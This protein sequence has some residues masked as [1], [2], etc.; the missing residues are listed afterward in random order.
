MFYLIGI[1]NKK[2]DIS[3]EGIDCIKEADEIYLEYYTSFYE[4]NLEELSNFLGKEIK[5]AD[6][7]LVE[8]KIDSILEYKS[9]NRDKKVALLV[10][11]D[12]LSATTHVDLLLRCKEKD[13]N[14]K[15]I[16]NISI[17]TLVART[18][19]QIYKFGKTT[20]VP[21]F[22][23]KFKPI[24]PLKILK[25]NLSIEAHTLFLLDIDP[26]NEKYLKAYEALSYLLD[27]SKENEDYKKSIRENTKVVVCSKLNTPDEKIFYGELTK[28]VEFDK[29]NNLKPPVC[30]I[31][32]GRLHF[33]E[34]DFLKSH[35]I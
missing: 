26:L 19:L 7:E 13:I 14:Y 2:E 20:S 29:K 8:Q 5:I 10:I 22:S 30:I 17:F 11:G 12:P 25:D 1:G 24:T 9:K 3:F 21:F 28:L 6:R 32:P 31:I 23:E 27:L 15:I 16:N 18:G 34:E 33:I 4:N 35:E